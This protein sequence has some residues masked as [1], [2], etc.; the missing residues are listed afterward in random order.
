MLRLVSEVPVLE[1]TLMRVLIMG[2]SKDIHVSPSDAVELADQ[3]VKRAAQLHHDG[4][5][6]TGLSRSCFAA[7][8][9]WYKL[10]F[11]SN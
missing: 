5:C 8:Q 7:I 1:D 4:Q 2:L 3:L 9:G 6:S 10:K 11:I